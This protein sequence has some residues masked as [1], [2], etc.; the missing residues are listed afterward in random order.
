MSKNVV[1]I[2]AFSTIFSIVHIKKINFD[3]STGKNKRT[4]STLASNF[5]II[6]TEY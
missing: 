1:Y 2:L 6:H 3:D 5:L 4:K